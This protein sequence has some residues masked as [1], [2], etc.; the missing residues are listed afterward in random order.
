MDTKKYD[1]ILEQVN[2]ALAKK[3][4][5]LPPEIDFM[6]LQKAHI[7]QESGFDANAVTPEPNVNDYS[8]GLMQLRI[9][10]AR[11]VGNF[12]DTVSDEEIQTKLLDPAFNATL[13]SKYILYQLKRYNYDL[14]KA[15]AAYNAGTAKY[16]SDGVTF[17]NQGYVDKVFKNYNDFIAEKKSPMK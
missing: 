13:G 6:S 10:T 16:K 8:I 11:G 4:V 9:D 3:I 14:K 1:Q 17:I 2:K 5:L 7:K 12:P 15:I